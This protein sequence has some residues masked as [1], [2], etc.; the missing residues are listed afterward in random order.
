M[1]KYILRR[2]PVGYKLFGLRDLGR[3]QLIGM[4]DAEGIF[5]LNDDATAP[6]D[7]V[8][9][10]ARRSAIDIN[11]T[12]AQITN[13][14]GE[15]CNAIES[16]AFKL[17]DATTD[18]LIKAAYDLRS[19]V[20]SGT[21]D[22]HRKMDVETEKTPEYYL[23]FSLHLTRQNK[24]EEALSALKDAEAAGYSNRAYLNEIKAGICLSLKDVDGAFD[25]LSLACGGA[26]SPA[27]PAR[28]LLPRF[29]KNGHSQKFSA[30]LKA[31][32]DGIQ[33][34][35]VHN[36]LARIAEHEGDAQGAIS[37]NRLALKLDPTSYS[38]GR[39]LIDAAFNTSD[40]DLARDVFKLAAANVSESAHMQNAL[41]RLR[42]DEKDFPAAMAAT[43]IAVAME[44]ENSNFWFIRGVSL[45][46]GGAL[47][48]A[49][50]AFETAVALTPTAAYSHYNLSLCA[51]Q[52]KN[53]ELANRAAQTAVEL[54]PNNQTFAAQLAVVIASAPPTNPETA[55]V[56]KKPI[57]VS[58]KA[59]IATKATA[60]K[61]NNP[62]WPRLG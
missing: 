28:A 34:S 26:A 36:M 38:A 7:L 60:T 24:N 21:I 33:Q 6:A 14:I 46:R 53:M 11:N 8:A 49:M 44:P 29:L 16:G 5:N 10:L 12:A 61:P 27:R 59:K 22:L 30:W 50:S 39:A 45:R 3:K 23:D 37:Q 13:Q 25:A 52:L 55:P 19:T 18:L 15:F 20:V 41:A 58:A 62:N 17:D 31:F 51:A 9:A 47:E 57:A 4:V 48:D 1:D 32:S 43:A 56:K 42:M 40:M 35:W 54:A 2:M